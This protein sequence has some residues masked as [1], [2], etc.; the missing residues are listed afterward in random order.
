LYKNVQN[1]KKLFTITT[2]CLFFGGILCILH[3]LIEIDTIYLK[4]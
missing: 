1:S 2:I 3:N 4:T